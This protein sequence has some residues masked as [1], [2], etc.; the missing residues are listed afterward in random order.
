MH[1][2]LPPEEPPGIFTRREAVII[3]LVGILVGLILGAIAFV[4][5]R[6]GFSPIA[7]FRSWFGLG[8]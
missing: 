1:L 5:V 4:M 6:T 8:P 7:A 3:Q 2:S